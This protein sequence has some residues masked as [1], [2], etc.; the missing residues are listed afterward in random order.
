M[1]EKEQRCKLYKNRTKERKDN[2]AV[3]KKKIYALLNPG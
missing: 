2:G 1:A 3:E